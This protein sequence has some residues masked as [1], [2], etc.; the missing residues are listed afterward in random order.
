MT[1]AHRGAG[2]PR[3]P[4]RKVSAIAS[5]WTIMRRLLPLVV[6]LV[7]AVAPGAR[8]ATVGVEDGV[9]VYEAAPGEAN[10][11]DIVSDPDVPGLVYLYEYSEGTT[12]PGGGCVPVPDPLGVVFGGLYLTFHCTGVESSD[13]RLGDGA[14]Y[15]GA[16]TEQ[17]AVADGGD[18]SDQ[19]SGS[20]AD[21]TLR[22]GAGDDVLVGGPARDTLDGGPGDDVLDGDYA[23]FGGGDED[24]AADPS[25]GGPDALDGG[26]GSDRLR[27]G[28]GADTLA[29]GDG[30][31]TVEYDNRTAGVVVTLDG[32]PDDG[33]AGENDAVGADVEGVLTGM[34]PDTVTGGAGPNQIATGAGDDRVDPGAG[35]DKVSTGEGGDTITARDG[36]ED[37]IECGEGVPDRVVADAGDITAAD[38]EV[39]ERPGGGGGPGAPARV[40]PQKLSLRLIAQRRGR[41]VAVRGRLALPAGAAAACAGATVRVTLT[42]AR[43]PLRFDVPLDARCRF[44][45]AV[46]YRARKGRRVAGRAAFAGTA[47][48]APAASRRVRTGR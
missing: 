46:P 41:L 8:A 33:G 2:Y 10:A 44:R 27:G 31:D 35:P 23:A 9:L 18:G 30:E 37:A 17:P 24:E 3:R 45:A 42:G 34:G 4:I 26:P 43:R 29:G 25:D 15:A 12:T 19:I 14:D 47:G 28:T 11:F 22:G 6:L 48:L 39:V 1:D 7:L 38:C 40:T 36:A 20:Y 16:F 21:D 32:R 13:L 5:V